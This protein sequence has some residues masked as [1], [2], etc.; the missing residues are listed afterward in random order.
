MKLIFNS[1]NSQHLTLT[2]TFGKHGVLHATH[3]RLSN[4]YLLIAISGG[5][6]R[7]RTGDTSSVAGQARKQAFRASFVNTS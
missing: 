7:Q 4:D 3:Q 5:L 6:N 2:L 1:N